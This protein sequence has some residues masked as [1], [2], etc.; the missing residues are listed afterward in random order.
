[1]DRAVWFWMPAFA[2]AQKAGIT[3]IAA[4][5][6][7]KLVLLKRTDVIYFFKRVKLKDVREKKLQFHKSS[8]PFSPF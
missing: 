7:F 6:S 4:S 8:Y 3:A 5:Q 2:R 1:M